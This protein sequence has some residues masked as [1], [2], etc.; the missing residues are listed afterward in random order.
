M[1]SITTITEHGAD[2]TGA[3]LSTTAIQSAIDQVAKSGGGTVRVTPGRYVTGTITLRSNLCLEIQSG[4][5]IEGSG[6]FEDYTEQ[7]EGFIEPEFPYVRCL[8]VGFDLENVEITGGGTVDGAG[9]KFMDYTQTTHDETF[10]AEAFEDM[11]PERRDEYVS[12]HEMPRPTWIFFLRRCTNIRFQDFRIRDVVRWTT[13]FSQC[14]NMVVSGMI[15]END[16]RAAN[17]DGMHFTSCRNVMISDC[18][19]TSGDDCIAITNY[20]DNDVDTFGVTVTNCV[21]TSHSAGVRIGFA[22]ESLLEDVVV[23][24]CVFRRC[25]RAV[26]I[27]AGT[28]A[29]VRHIG[30]SNIEITTR[31][32]AGTWWGKAEP[33][34]ITTLGEGGL[35]EDVRISGVSARSEQGI[36]INASSGASVRGVTLADVRLR[37]SA[38]EMTPFAAGTLDLRPLSMERRALP[39]LLASGVENL[40][41]RNL[42]IEID[43]DVR[44]VFPNAV[45]FVGCRG[46]A[47]DGLR[48]HVSRVRT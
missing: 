35:I 40:T 36:V 27:F 39:A 45:E 10:T 4:A 17:S 33:F 34:M 9:A 42:E 22:E 20:G 1:S 23:S 5:T 29:T 7:E 41:I 32:I 2:P 14:R 19:I 26:G 28:N 46:L 12:E 31:L 3:K 48:E 8:F 15:I 44:T 38:G 25:N 21:L 47:I 6:E 16:L 30:I 24:N 37:L 13:R 43:D 11:S 18:S